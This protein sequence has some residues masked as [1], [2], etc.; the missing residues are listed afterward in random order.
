MKAILT[1]TYCDQIDLNL[2]ETAAKASGD[3]PA[4]GE[5][6]QENLVKK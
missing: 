6:T 3:D 4:A 1:I 5:A 2:S